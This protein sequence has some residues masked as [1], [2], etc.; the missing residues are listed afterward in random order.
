MLDDNLC[1][2]PLVADLA[3]GIASRRGCAVLGHQR[4]VKRNV[5]VCGTALQCRSL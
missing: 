5:A 2:G 1:G 4:D 3:F